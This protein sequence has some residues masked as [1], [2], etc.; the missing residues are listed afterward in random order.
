M[1]YKEGIDK[2]NKLIE[3]LKSKYSN[4]DETC[5]DLEGIK[6]LLQ[7]SRNELCLLCEKYKHEHEGWCKDCRFRG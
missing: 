6:D 2:T 4:T 3:Y 5:K 1:D 7:T